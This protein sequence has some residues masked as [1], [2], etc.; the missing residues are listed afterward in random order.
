MFGT[1]L[2]PLRRFREGPYDR[3]AASTVIRTIEGAGLP[4]LVTRL[5]GLFVQAPEHLVDLPSEDERWSEV[6]PFQQKAIEA[7]NLVICEFVLNEVVSAAASVADMVIGSLE[8]DRVEFRA[9]AGGQVTYFERTMLPF[10]LNQEGWFSAQLLNHQVLDHID[11]VRRAQA[12]ASI[13]AS[14]PLFVIGAYSNFSRLQLSEAVLDAFI[15]VEQM[16]DK[17]WQDWPGSASPTG[18]QKRPSDRAFDD[19]SYRIGKLHAD[20][21]LVGPIYDAIDAAR[22]AR[23]FVAHRGVVTDE[24]ASTALEALRLLLARFLKTE[25]PAAIH[26]RG[27]TW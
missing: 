10:Y 27:L 22:L 25:V 8:D 13:A 2:S 19:V 23:N 26:I 20:G 24:A 4:V 21:V 6:G 17:L 18:P 14:M 5:G 12:L 16:I 7:I 1:H 3:L 15:V 9:L 11:G